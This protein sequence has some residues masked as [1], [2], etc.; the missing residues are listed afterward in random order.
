MNITGYKK[1]LK[2]MK[3]ML[4]EAKSQRDSIARSKK[5]KSLENHIPQCRDKIKEL[6]NREKVHVI[7]GKFKEHWRYIKRKQKGATI[8]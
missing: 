7:S 4:K 5:I 1:H 8:S 2:A 6:Q 3:S